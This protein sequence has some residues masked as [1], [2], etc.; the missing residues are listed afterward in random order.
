MGGEDHVVGAV[1]DAVVGVGSE[2]VQELAKVGL[3]EFSGCCLGGANF[4]EG[5]E[6]LVVDCPTVILGGELIKN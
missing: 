2:V 6:E 4:A 1:E 3:G 5:K